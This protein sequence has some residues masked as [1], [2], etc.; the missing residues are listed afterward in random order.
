MVT[1]CAACHH[2]HLALDKLIFRYFLFHARSSQNVLQRPYS[3]WGG[4]EIDNGKE[5]QKMVMG[6]STLGGELAI[7]YIYMMDY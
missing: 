3:K 4:K 5:G 2:L 7:Q 6:D 1:M